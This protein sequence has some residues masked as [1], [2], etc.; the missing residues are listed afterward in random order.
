M[1]NLQNEKPIL[2]DINISTLKKWY[3][4]DM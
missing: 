4:L 3:S 1:A 2:A